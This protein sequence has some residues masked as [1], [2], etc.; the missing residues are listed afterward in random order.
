MQTASSKSATVHNPE[1]TE[2]WLRAL[3]AGRDEKGVKVIRRAA[4]YAGQAHA[5]QSRASGDPYISHALSVADILRELGLDYESIAAAILHDVVEDTD[6]TIDEI[7]SEFGAVIA[8]LVDGVTKMDVIHAFSESK[9]ADQARERA[10]AESLRKM[11]IA[12]VEDVRVVLIKLAD[13]LH[14][15]RTLKPLRPGETTAHCERNP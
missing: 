8:R 14:N 13:R 1:E 10:K 11:L 9:D 3:T 15:M 4:E 6:I 12:M 5:G 2:A 7:A